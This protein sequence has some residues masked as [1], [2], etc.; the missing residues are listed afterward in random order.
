MNVFEVINA[1]VTS[2]NPTEE[3]NKL[4]ME[5]VLK[6]M[7]ADGDPCPNVVTSVLGLQSCKGCSCPIYKKVYTAAGPSAC[8]LKKWEN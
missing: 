5:R 6:C 8:P 3:Q 1:W 2:I 7:P 4:A